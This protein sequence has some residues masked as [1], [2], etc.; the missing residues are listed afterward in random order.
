MVKIVNELQKSKVVAL[1]D[2]MI[3]KKRK[4]AYA[5]QSW[6]IHQ[7][8]SYI[9][10]PKNSYIIAHLFLD[11][12]TPKNGGLIFWAGSHKEEY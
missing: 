1:N 6:T 3:Y 8:N 11:D 7:D 5:G 9:R 4:T 2:Q 10:A 12:S